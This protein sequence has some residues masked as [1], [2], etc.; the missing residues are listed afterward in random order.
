VSREDR[1][2][3]LGALLRVAYQA[4]QDEVVRWLPTSGYDDLQFAH[5]TAVAPLWELPEGA[6]VTT[7]ARISRITKQ[8]MSEHVDHLE[9]QGYVERI[10]DPND[11]RA[12]LVKLTPRGRALGRAIR[13]F[14]RGV[15]ADFSRRIG[16]K[17]VEEL[18]GA[19]EALRESLITRS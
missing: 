15:E 7:L 2:P 5:C 17:R 6:R 18:R 16:A 4:M 12:T 10:A 8:S 9:A 13:G 14:V 11:A 19:L 3:L 1:K